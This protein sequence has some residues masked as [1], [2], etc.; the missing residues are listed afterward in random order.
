MDLKTQPIPNIIDLSFN[1]SMDETKTEFLALFSG[2][3][4]SIAGGGDPLW[5]CYVALLRNTLT[6]T[7]YRRGMGEVSVADVR[8]AASFM[9]FQ[10][11]SAENSAIHTS[12]ESPPDWFVEMTC[13]ELN[14]TT[15]GGTSR[16]NIPHPNADVLELLYL[17]Y[18]GVQMGT[19]TAS[20]V[21][22]PQ[23][24]SVAPNG[25]SGKYYALDSP[26][27]VQAQFFQRELEFLDGEEENEEEEQ[28]VPSDD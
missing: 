17:I 21:A 23:R 2:T 13:E 26:V 14:E 4:T 27:G 10:V 24:A 7:S 12:N 22:S 20:V 6:M 16:S 28:E 15:R 3:A 25:G 8:Y 18:R 11:P 5:K 19:V 9:G 1:T